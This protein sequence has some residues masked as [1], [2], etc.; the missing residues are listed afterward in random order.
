MAA[1]VS[2]QKA[3]AKIGTPGKLNGLPVWKKDGNW[4]ASAPRRACV[5][6]SACKKISRVL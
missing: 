5:Y 1:V 4:K 2:F 6:A 3:Q